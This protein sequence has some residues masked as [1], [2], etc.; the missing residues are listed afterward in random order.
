MKSESYY[1][2]FCYIQ[3]SFSNLN[4]IP[5]RSL[6]VLHHLLRICFDAWR[7]NDCVV[8]VALLPWGQIC[9]VLWIAVNKVSVWASQAPH[10]TPLQTDRTIAS[11]RDPLWHTFG[12]DRP[13]IGLF[14]RQVWSPAKTKRMDSQL[15][16]QKPHK[17]LQ[18]KMPFTHFFQNSKYYETSRLSVIL[19]ITRRKTKHSSERA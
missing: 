14:L 6:Y 2:N 18:W 7:A 19:N 11:P 17:H 9:R 5:I 10:M 16:D 13:V 3:T 4:R 15:L 1:D 8:T 12:S